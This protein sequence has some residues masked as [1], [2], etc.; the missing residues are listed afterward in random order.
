MLVGGMLIAIFMLALWGCTQWLSEMAELDR[1]TYA[2]F[3]QLAVWTTVGFFTVV[4]F[5]SYL[6]LRIRRE[7]W[8]V[9]LKMRAEA[10]RLQSELV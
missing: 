4:R 7:G 6:D 5:L 8:E 1:F 10:A 2:V 3:F 9:E